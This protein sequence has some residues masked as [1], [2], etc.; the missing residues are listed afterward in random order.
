[1]LE[2]TI[3]EL[4]HTIHPHPTIS[5]TITE[6]AHAAKGGHSPL[7]LTPQG[8]KTVKKDEI[9]PVTMPSMGEGVFEATVNRWLKNVGI[10]WLKTSHFLSVSTDKVDTEIVSPQKG[11]LI[12]TFVKLEKIQVAQEIAQIASHAMPRR[13]PAGNPIPSV[14]K[15]QTPELTNDRPQKTYPSLTNSSSYSTLPTT[16]AGAVR[17]SPL[18]R[19]LARELHVPLTQVTGTG[20][21][22]RI[23]KNDLMTFLQQGGTRIPVAS[24]KHSSPMGQQRVVTQ[25]KDGKEY[26]EAVAVRR[27]PMSKVRQL[28]ADHMLKSVQISPHVTTTFEVNLHHVQRLKQH[29]GLEFKQQHGS[30]LTYTAFFLYAAIQ[31]IKKFPITNASVDHH[32]ILYKEDINLGCVG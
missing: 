17:S 3:D 10:S 29:H 11:Y 8:D 1:M 24:S 30:K 26:L 18:V 15:S 16:T 23:T 27:E 25:K 28:T 32:D 20:L 19:K 21:Y 2:T 5:E 31:G 4:A 14:G 6:V 22:G 13:K 9:I 12:A 7:G